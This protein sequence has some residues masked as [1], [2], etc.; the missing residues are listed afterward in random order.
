M[1]KYFA[2]ELNTAFLRQ[3]AG[4]DLQLVAG[5]RAET[6]EILRGYDND[7]ALMG[8]PPSDF[9]AESEPLR[10]SSLG[11]DCLSRLSAGANETGAR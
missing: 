1:A 9:A 11:H 8:R 6:D 2:A 3:H 7:I 4:I 10:T 5:N